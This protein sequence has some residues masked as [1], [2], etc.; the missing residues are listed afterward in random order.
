MND[1]RLPYKFNP[2]RHRRLMRYTKLRKLVL[3]L[4]I[5]SVSFLLT[6]ALFSLSADIPVSWLVWG[7]LLSIG[8]GM[9]LRYISHTLIQEHR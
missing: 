3:L 4:F 2:E 6:A 9:L 8:S 5:L 7:T 1:Y